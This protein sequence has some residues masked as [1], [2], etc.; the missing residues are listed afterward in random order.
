MTAHL[1]LT[2]LHHASPLPP[3]RR[4]VPGKDLFPILDAAKRATVVMYL[5]SDAGQ[6]EMWPA[7]KPTLT[8]GKTLYFSH[9]FSIA[10]AK[11]TG[12]WTGRGR[13]TVSRGLRLNSPALAPFPRRHNFH[14]PYLAPRST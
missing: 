1:A 2:R 13:V 11:D 5:L 12:E 3:Y 4:W 6:K 9:G 10:F 8:K 7:L 14:V